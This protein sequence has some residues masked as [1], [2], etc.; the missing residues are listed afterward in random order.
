VRLPSRPGFPLA[1][2]SNDLV[3]DDLVLDDLVLD[4]GRPARGGGSGRAGRVFGGVTGR[5]AG[6]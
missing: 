2:V 1:K 5:Q 3:L 6:Q 4:D